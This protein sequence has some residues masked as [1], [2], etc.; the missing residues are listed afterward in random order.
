LKRKIVTISEGRGSLH[1]FLKS[2]GWVT[3]LSAGVGDE[4]MHCSSIAY[5][6]GMSIHLTDSGLAKVVFFIFFRSF[7][8]KRTFVTPYV[9]V[10]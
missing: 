1:S 6:F 4:G 2:R 3:S 5:I 8:Q 9:N 10:S 7:S